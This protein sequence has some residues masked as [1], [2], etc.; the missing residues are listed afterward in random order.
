[1]T[2]WRR[3]ARKVRAIAGRTALAEHL[4]GG[5]VQRGEQVRRAVRRWGRG[6]W[7]HPRCRSLRSPD[8]SVVLKSPGERR[9]RGGEVGWWRT[10]SWSASTITVLRS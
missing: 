5:D 10:C 2:A 6:R 7:A 4:T 8:T 3:N 9:S 1:V